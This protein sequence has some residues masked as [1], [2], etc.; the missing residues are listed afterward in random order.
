MTSLLYAL[1]LSRCD[2]YDQAAELDE[3]QR[4]D[5]LDDEY[6]AECAADDEEG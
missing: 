5:E 6:R 4:Q 2:S 1:R 3:E